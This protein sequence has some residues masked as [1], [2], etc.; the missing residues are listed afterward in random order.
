MSTSESAVKYEVESVLSLVEDDAGGKSPAKPHLVLH[1]LQPTENS[2]SWFSFNDYC[3][4]EADEDF[5]LDFTNSWRTPICLVFRNVNFCDD[6][7]QSVVEI[8][9]RTQPTPFYTP[10]S[11]GAPNMW[12]LGP[13]LTIVP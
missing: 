9:S 7:F 11:L 4:A 3:I 8:A 12:Y 13:F 1:S 2:L 6:A 5:I 10:I